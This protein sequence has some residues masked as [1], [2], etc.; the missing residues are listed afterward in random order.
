DAE[1]A[2]V[3]PTELLQTLL[4]R[5]NPGL[6]LWTAVGDPAQHADPSCRTGLLRTRRK[7]PS[8]RAAEQRDELA[9]PCMS[10]KQHCEAGRGCGPDLL[11]VATG[12][13]QPLRIPNRE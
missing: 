11:P 6:R 4:E 3:R 9:P 10:G 7:R 13:P 2:A 1:I 5:G 12:S 8:R